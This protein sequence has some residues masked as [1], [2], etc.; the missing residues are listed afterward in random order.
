MREVRFRIAISAQ[1]YLKYYQKRVD[2]V[3]VKTS[4]GRIVQFPA[5]AL[6]KYLDQKGVNGYFRIVYD[7]D[8]KLVSLEKVGS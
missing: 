7:D 3:L 2:A 8:N 1:D 4:D 6:Q 5:G